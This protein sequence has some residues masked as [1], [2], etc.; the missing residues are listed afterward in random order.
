[1]DARGWLG[2]VVLGVVS[3]T[4]W[5]SDWP[6]QDG[7]WPDPIEILRDRTDLQESDKRAMFVDGPARFFGIDLDELLAHLGDGWDRQAPIDGIGG[8]LEATARAVA[9]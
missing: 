9:V 1:M 7:A 3:S 6:H 5:A 8:M 2:V 4:L